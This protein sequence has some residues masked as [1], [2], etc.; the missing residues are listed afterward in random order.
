MYSRYIP[1]IFS[2]PHQRYPQIWH[3]L[4]E[5][6]IVERMKILSRRG[7]PAVSALDLD[8]RPIWNALEDARAN[9]REA[10]IKQM[11]GHQIRQ[12]LEHEG[13]IK[14]TSK[15]IRTS[16]IFSSGSVYEDPEWATLY[17][18]RNQDSLDPERYCVSSKRDV[19][20]LDDPPPK[21]WIAYR[22]C[23]TLN[24]LH[25]VLD[26]DLNDAFGWSWVRLCDSVDRDGYVI[27]KSGS[28]FYTPYESE[29]KP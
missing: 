10:Q 2:Q 13:Y 19:A 9:G 20:A 3:T 29:M 27:L 12:I 28:D 25:Y 8:A 6:G 15:P 22:M 7:F 14:V 21:Q 18:S 16:W 5:P 1:E 26:A 24:E 11:I 23:R 17:I 4:N